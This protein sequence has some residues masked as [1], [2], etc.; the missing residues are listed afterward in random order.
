MLLVH[1]LVD[2]VSEE[3]KKAGQQAA[4][5]LQEKESDKKEKT[6]IIQPEGGIRYTVPQKIRTESMEEDGPRGNGTDYFEKIRF[7]TRVEI[8]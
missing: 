8:R 5:F 6:I 7:D 3:A 1:V 4:A 2:Y